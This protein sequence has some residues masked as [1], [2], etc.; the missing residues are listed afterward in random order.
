MATLRRMPSDPGAPPVPELDRAACARITRLALR[1][2]VPFFV[3]AIPFAFVVGIA[4]TESEMPTF[5]AWLTSPLIFAGAAQL[6]VITLAGTATV[7]SVIL[8]GLVINLRHTMYSAA[9]APRLRT[10]PAWFRW[11]APYVLIDQVFALTVMRVDDPH[12]DLGLAQSPAAL[13]RYYSTVGGF[14]WCTWVAVTTL[15]MVV[16]PVIPQSWQL[17]FAV[18]IMFTGMVLLGLDK[19]PQAAAALA[20]GLASLAAAGL[21][22]RLGILV[23]A[24]VGVL[25]GSLAEA[26]WGQ[27]PLRDRRAS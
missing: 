21:Q 17:G 22:N 5:V 27:A 13:R 19:V 6:A 12:S 23:G 9:L 7:W 14:F 26:R 24:A 16:G 11:L 4:M 25:A 8:A 20:G 3:P 1:D 2:A 18:P 10:Q 15:G